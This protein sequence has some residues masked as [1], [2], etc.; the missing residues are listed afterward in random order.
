MLAALCCGSKG[1]GPKRLPRGESSAPVGRR[2]LRH[3]ADPESIF[4]LCCLIRDGFVTQKGLFPVENK[5]GSPIVWERQEFLNRIIR[6][7]TDDARVR[8]MQEVVTVGIQ[9]KTT[10][11]AL[12][13]SRLV[14][15]KTANKEIARVQN[16][17]ETTLARRKAIIRASPVAFA[18][19]PLISTHQIIRR[20]AAI[21]ADT[22]PRMPL[23]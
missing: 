12:L 8:P 7:A 15:K 21:T 22:P 6:Y 23:T 13:S 9:K 20:S 2:A 16:M 14:K 10:L 18:W 1:M 17:G 4:G 19:L 11:K 3:T 5:C